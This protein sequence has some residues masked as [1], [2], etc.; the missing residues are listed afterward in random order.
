MRMSVKAHGVAMVV[1][2]KLEDEILRA[3]EWRNSRERV[4]FLASES[5]RMVTL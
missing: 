3:S 1:A 5:K 4:K 2:W